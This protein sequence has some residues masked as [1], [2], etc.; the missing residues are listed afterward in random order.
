MNPAFTKTKSPYNA[1]KWTFIAVFPICCAI[2]PLTDF[3]HRKAFA[4]CRSSALNPKTLNIK[5]YIAQPHEGKKDELSKA[6][7]SL[8]NCEITPAQNKDVLVVVTETENKDE[9]KELLEKLEAIASMKLLTLV[10]GFN[11]SI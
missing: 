4:D 5:S 3:H 8:S 10:S 7:S 2:V 11:T 6:I 9:E 1:Q